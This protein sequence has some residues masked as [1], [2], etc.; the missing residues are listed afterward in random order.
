MG[1][2]GLTDTIS[3]VSHQRPSLIAE[4]A[5]FQPAYC[6]S[7]GI[8][9]LALAPLSCPHRSSGWPSCQALLAGSSSD[10]SPIRSRPRQTRT[11]SGS[12]VPLP[13]SSSATTASWLLV[14]TAFLGKGHGF[15]SSFDAAGSAPRAGG[16]RALGRVRA[17][18][19]PEHPRGTQS[20]GSTVPTRRGPGQ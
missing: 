1:E 12:R 7:P 10:N 11:T 9:D 4:G 14:E 18:R 17:T 13:A 6:R 20:P 8:Y 5:C 2:A 3:Q 16:A 19:A 15:R